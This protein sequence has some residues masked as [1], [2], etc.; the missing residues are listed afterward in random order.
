MW[1]FSFAVAISVRIMPQGI[2][3]FLAN[4]MHPLVLLV[5]LLEVVAGPVLADVEVSQLLAIPLGDLLHSLGQVV[6]W[7]LHLLAFVNLILVEPAPL[8]I[9]SIDSLL[10]VG[11][12][13]GIVLEER[14]AYWLLELVLDTDLLGRRIPV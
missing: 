10:L 8:R 4:V 12:F 5:Q 14:S 2:A 1:L 11:A 6:D 9:I 13:V 7:L 3:D